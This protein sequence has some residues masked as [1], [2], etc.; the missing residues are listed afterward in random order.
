MK[1]QI[2]TTTLGEIRALQANGIKLPKILCDNGDNITWSH[3]ELPQIAAD[4]LARH[5]EANVV[6]RPEG[7]LGKH[8]I[9]CY[10]RWNRRSTIASV[11]AAPA[12]HRAAELRA[13]RVRLKMAR[14]AIA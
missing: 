1:K 8:L 13:Y 7:R 3:F 2:E 9:T 4:W 14:F 10:R 11:L 12:K 6:G 5:P